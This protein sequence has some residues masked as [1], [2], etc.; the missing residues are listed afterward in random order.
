MFLFLTVQA[1][2]IMV[3]PKYWVFLDKENRPASY[4]KW[5]SVPHHIEEVSPAD[6]MKHLGINKDDDEEP[7]RDAAADAELGGTGPATD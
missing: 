1:R 6:I 5:T 2:F 7:G 4:K 3:S